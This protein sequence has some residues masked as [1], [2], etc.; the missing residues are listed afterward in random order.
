MSIPVEIL[1]PITYASPEAAPILSPM[2]VSLGLFSTAPESPVAL[3]VA[4]WNPLTAA[5]REGALAFLPLPVELA[6]VVAGLVAGVVVAVAG[7]AGV[8]VGAVAGVAGVVVAVLGA[9]VVA[10]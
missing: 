6:A 1:P 5:R 4:R 10:V 3:T 7:A 2:P 8:V 9:A